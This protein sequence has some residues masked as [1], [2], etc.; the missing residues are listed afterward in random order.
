VV[1]IDESKFGKRKYH[2]GHRV[3]GVWVVGGVEKTPERKCFLA[4]VNNRNTE[5][6]DTIIQNYVADGSV[7]HTDC[8]RAYENMVNLGMNLIH[9]TINYSV[10]FR[11]GDVHTNTMESKNNF[12][13]YKG[14]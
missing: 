11:D 10:T 12:T 6:M 2:R 8:W 4:V 14:L 1:E 13:M 7:V 5:T 3:E 9:R